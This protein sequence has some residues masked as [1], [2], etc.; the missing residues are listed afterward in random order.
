[1]L[2]GKIQIRRLHLLPEDC[3]YLKFAVNWSWWSAFDLVASCWS[4]VPSI[5]RCK[6]VAWSWW[7]GLLLLRFADVIDLHEFWTMIC[8]PDDLLAYCCTASIDLPKPAKVIGDLRFGIGGQSL[9]SV[10]VCV[11]VKMPSIVCLSVQGWRCPQLV[12]VYGSK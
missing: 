1:M 10:D 5:C 6:K 7:S 11:N 12:V 8:R 4:A 2:G 3:S 9:Q